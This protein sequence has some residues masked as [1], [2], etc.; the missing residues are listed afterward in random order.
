MNDNGIYSPSGNNTSA[1][2]PASAQKQTAQNN[3]DTHMSPADSEVKNNY[4]ST[5]NYYSQDYDDY[6]Y[7]AQLR[8]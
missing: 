5:D 1:S 2:Q 8:R 6:N 7:S 4:T 3:T